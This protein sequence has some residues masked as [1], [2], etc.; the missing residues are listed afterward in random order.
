MDTSLL[1][2]ILVVLVGA[3]LRKYRPDTYNSIKD[4]VLSLVKRK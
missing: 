2:V 1:I 4:K 3:T